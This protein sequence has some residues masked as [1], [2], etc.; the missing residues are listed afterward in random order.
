MTTRASPVT[1]DATRRG[2]AGR[3]IA[4]LA[5]AMILPATMA[6]GAED[7]PARKMLK[8]MSDYVSS[9]KVVEATFDSDIEVL[10]SEMQK[11][12]FTSSGQLLLSRP[13]RLR[14]SRMG[15]YTDVELVFD[16]S[17]LTVNDRANGSYAQAA[18]GSVDEVIGKLR[19]QYLVEAPGADLLLSNSY[20]ALTENVID[21][22]HIGEG[23]IDGVECQHLAFRTEET[24]WQ[25]WIQSGERP[26]PRKYVITSK[27]VTGAPQ[28][29]LRIKEWKTDAQVADNA[30]TFSPPGSAKKVEF[31]ELAV[32]DEVPPGTTTGAGR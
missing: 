19:D 16:G 31:K 21:A 4:A 20:G 14:V 11:L 13:D 27:T 7:D 3:R 29:T 24:D 17:T 5:A 23:V 22:M 2:G 18:A 1:T 15:G 8:A 12:Q 32:I 28:Y 25:I 30:F 9:Q 26:I 6:L 10:T